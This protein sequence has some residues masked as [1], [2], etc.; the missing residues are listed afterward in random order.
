MGNFSYLKDGLDKR[1]LLAA[2]ITLIC[3]I[4][5]GI[6]LYKLVNINIYIINFASDYVYEVFAFKNGALIL[7]RF[8]YGVFFAYL[9]FGIAHFTK[10][11]YLTLALIFIRS[12]MFAIYAAVLISINSF[13]GS[14]VAFTVYIPSFAVSFAVCCVC[15]EF[16][17]LNVKRIFLLPLICTVID[18]LTML[19]LVNIVFRAIIVIA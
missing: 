3:G 11:K 10:L 13:G 4:V 12:I 17:R 1:Y 2:V 8:I 14:V 19:L 15:A 9:F 6:V 7:T 18:V 16:S 5:C